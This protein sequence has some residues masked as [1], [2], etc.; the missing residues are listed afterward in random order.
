MP[1]IESLIRDLLS[2]DS[3]VRDRAA[4]QLMETGDPRAVGPLLQAISRPEN[5]DRRGTLVYAL[6]AF[7]GEPH[8]ETLVD[9]ALTGNLEVSIGAFNLIDGTPRSIETRSRVRAELRKYTPGALAAEHHRWAFE[10]LSD[11]VRRES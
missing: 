2:P 10:A 4:M 11:F 7:D 9:L 6:S 1:D 5:T 8:L 3:A